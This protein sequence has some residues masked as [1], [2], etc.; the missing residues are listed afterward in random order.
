MS[1]SGFRHRGIEVVVD[2]TLPA[3]FDMAGF[4]LSENFARNLVHRLRTV[5]FS[6]TDRCH[7]IV[8]IR[9]IDGYDVLF[10]VGREEKTVVITIG[11]VLIAESRSTTQELMQRANAIATLR[12]ALGI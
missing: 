9:E 7:G 10:V 12:G 6:A 2:T 8:R 11:G 4:Q 5:T 1:D 3:E